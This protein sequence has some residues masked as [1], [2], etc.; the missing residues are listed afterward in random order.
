MKRRVYKDTDDTK[1]REKL[2]K[3][4]RNVI[5]IK[6]RLYNENA[7]QKFLEKNPEI[8]PLPFILNHWLHFNAV[9]SKFRI[10]DYY[11]A[12]F[13]YLT[14]C[15]DFWFLVLLEIEAASKR[16]FTKSSGNICFHNE[17][18]K[19]YDQILHWKA[20]INDNYAEIRKRINCLLMPP[21]MGRNPIHFKY[22]LIL[23]R[24]GEKDADKKRRLITQR[25]TEN[26][27]VMTFDSIISNYSSGPVLRKIILSHHRD[28]FKIKRFQGVST[29][30]FSYLFPEYLCFSPDIKKEL[31]ADGYDIKS[32]E[33][34]E[35]LMICDKY[36]MS[37]H[38]EVITKIIKYQK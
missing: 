36:P 30:I 18:N 32:W 21:K 1:L 23:G 2:L 15:S 26:I 22:V 25:N 34:G 16:I 28:G 5:K 33:R 14:K 3:Q 17:F 12:D 19:A 8:I 7:I 6:D 4:F 31:M 24:D 27:R 11:I 10:S 9:L 20:Y 29:N 35:R 38:D 37:R 13:A